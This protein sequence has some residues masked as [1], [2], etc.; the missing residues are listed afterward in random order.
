MTPVGYAAM[1]GH[2]E[3]VEYLL[4]L[5]DLD[6]SLSGVSWVQYWGQH[7]VCTW[8]MFCIRLV[9]VSLNLEV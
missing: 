5:N 6:K 4:K 7:T 2:V 8:R 3:V 1:G 9:A